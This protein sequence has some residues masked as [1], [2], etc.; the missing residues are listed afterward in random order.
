MLI[1][2]I[3]SL[4]VPF[5]THPTI[6]ADETSLALLRAAQLL[7]LDDPES[8]E[9]IHAAVASVRRGDEEL[10]LVADESLAASVEVGLDETVIGIAGAGRWTAPTSLVEQLLSWRPV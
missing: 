7:P 4:W 1:T 9:R 3:D 8:L 5:L 2:G 6:V 10:V